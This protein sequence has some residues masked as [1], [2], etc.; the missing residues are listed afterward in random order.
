MGNFY[1]E[2]NQPSEIGSKYFDKNL[3][4]F[5]WAILAYFIAAVLILAENGYDYWYILEIQNLVTTYGWGHV[6][7]TLTPVYDPDSSLLTAIFI[8]GSLGLLIAFLCAMTHAR[9]CAEA[10]GI[11]GY[12]WSLRW[13][14]ISICVPFLNFVRPWLGF[15]EIRRSIIGSTEGIADS[16]SWRTVSFS[17]ATFLLGVLFNS[18]VLI[19]KIAFNEASRSL[20]TF[21]NTGGQLSNVLLNVQI[22]IASELICLAYIGWYLFSLRAPLINLAGIESSTHSREVQ[23]QATAGV[24]PKQTPATNETNDD[25]IYESIAREL[26]D[27][28]INQGLWT[29]L[30]AEA[31]GDENKT[32]ALYIKR[33]AE[34]LTEEK[35]K[36]LEEVK[37]MTLAEE[38][39]VRIETKRIARIKELEKIDLSS[40]SYDEI[41]AAIMQAGQRS[42]KEYRDKLLSLAQ[43]KVKQLGGQLFIN[44]GDIGSPFFISIRDNKWSANND[45]ELANILFLVR[46]YLE[47]EQA[48][49]VRELEQKVEL[50]KSTQLTS[51]ITERA[52]NIPSRS[53]LIDLEKQNKVFSSGE[54]T[55]AHAWDEALKAYVDQDLPKAFSLFQKAAELGDRKAM[56]HL[57]YLLQEGIGTKR[58]EKS[59]KRWRDEA[60]WLR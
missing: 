16:Q 18:S 27:K 35:N 50:K 22:G 26:A 19:N 57:A 3:D 9:R 25:E 59:S 32:K 39:E 43:E 48:A 44:K 4:N 24:Q 5:E 15:G 28:N 6:P 54:M 55:A 17:P 49:K 21:L 2:L 45:Q 52:E 11:S 10:I 46:G 60:L 38:E 36:K 14:M 34:I 41:A 30:F 1:K 13:T 23:P 12:R 33:R 42:S 53:Q 31:E 37:A 8:I 20:D 29:R 40:L 58:D 47:K 51:A 7:A 56:V